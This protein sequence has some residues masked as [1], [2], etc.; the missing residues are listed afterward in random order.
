MSTFFR[1]AVRGF[2]VATFDFFSAVLA[3]VLAC[4][5]SSASGVE[6]SVV[7]SVRFRFPVPAGDASVSSV[8]AAFV[9]DLKER[10]KTGAAGGLG[11]LLGG[12]VKAL[13]IPV[14]RIII[15]VRDKAVGEMGGFEEGMCVQALRLKLNPQA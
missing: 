7:P 2:F 4:E 12:M 10:V 8:A 3:F 5:T 11:A 6:L 14:V 13:W 1:T 9:L 15:V